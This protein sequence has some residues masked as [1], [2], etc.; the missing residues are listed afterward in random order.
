MNTPNKTGS[1]NVTISIKVQPEDIKSFRDPNQLGRKRFVLQVPVEEIAR[2]SIEF[3][4]NPRNQ[5]MGTRVVEAIQDTLISRP[6]WF[7][8]A[9]KGILMNA[10][11]AE[12]DNKTGELRL[13]LDRDMKNP[14][15]DSLGGNMDGGHTQAVIIQKIKVELWQN[16]ED[17]KERQWVNLEVLTGV[18]FEELSFIAGA[19][20]TSVSV[21]DLSLA[22]LNDELDWLIQ[23][24]EKDGTN[25]RIAWRQ[26]APERDV[27]GEEVLA[28]LSLL[29]PA[30]TDKTRC[31]VGA[32]SL[33]KGLRS[34]GSQPTPMM[35]ELKTAVQ[36]KAAK[37]MRLVD[38][39][40]NSM[41]EW[42]KQNKS[43]QGENGRFGGLCG[44][45]LSNKKNPH[46]LVFLRRTQNY[47]VAKSWLMP[48][49]YGFTIAFQQEQDE[50]FLYKLADSIGP[51][52]MEN[53]Y[54]I[55]ISEKKNLNAVGKNKSAW[56]SSMA[57][58]DAAYMRLKYE[59][60]SAQKRG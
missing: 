21:K 5:D 20:N 1:R 27:T 17:P 47:R 35:A 9:N 4:P 38:Y 15:G 56:T 8:Y 12:Y 19:R 37:W 48:I 51:K 58:V 50:N 33:I 16:F 52:L 44:V 60:G 59:P 49:V 53:I 25:Q 57:L 7:Q 3:G 42:W 40:H 24:F 46:Q 31:Y 41:E 11:D 14:W 36:G 30:V 39:V 22:V 45:Q 18:P 2:A 55:T 10:Q 32:G 26:F 23:E 13:E 6:A 29:N 43:D 28:Y 34:G 54:D